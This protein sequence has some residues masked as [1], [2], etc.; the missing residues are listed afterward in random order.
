MSFA[1]STPVPL[2]ALSSLPCRVDKVL[3]KGGVG[4]HNWQ[5]YIPLTNIAGSQHNPKILSIKVGETT[6]FVNS[7]RLPSQPTY[8]AYV[9]SG[10]S[11]SLGITGAR[12]SWCRDWFNGMMDGDSNEPPYQRA[13]RGRRRRGLT[14][15][16]PE[17]PCPSSLS[18]EAGS[19][20]W[21]RVLI[22]PASSLRGPIPPPGQPIQRGPDSEAFPRSSAS[23]PSDLHTKAPQKSRASAKFETLR[24]VDPGPNPVLIGLHSRERARELVPVLHRLPGRTAPLG[25][26][27]RGRLRAAKNLVFEPIT[28]IF[29]A[30]RR[31]WR[32]E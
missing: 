5:R 22:D 13:P 26:L 15:L 14:C 25:P 8:T 4:G 11:C 2:P 17:Q 29:F 27:S 31:E 19:N 30:E 7:R 1:I 21:R 9:C 24:P 28:A 6:P 23:P 18:A 16:T 10:L 20:G 3:V 32:V 12:S